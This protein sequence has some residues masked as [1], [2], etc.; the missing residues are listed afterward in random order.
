[1][2]DTS[3]VGHALPPVR[4]DVER[5]RLRQFAKA[6]GENRPEYVDQEA[7]RRLGWP[8][9]P[10]PLSFFFCLEMEQPDPWSFL[11]SLDVELNRVLHGEQSFV[12]HAP[13]WAGDRLTLS[14]KI[15][16]IYAKRDGALEFIVK[17]TAVTRQDQ[18]PI[19]D[20]RSILVVR[21]G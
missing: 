9:L 12:Y 20:L 11:Q 21:N 14:P 16:D 5:G 15:V 19:A 3:W 1:M 13:A 18:T 7:S 4:V 6:V 17:E 10:V 2:I 8:D